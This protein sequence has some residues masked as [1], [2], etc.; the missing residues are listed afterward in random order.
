M[1]HGNPYAFAS[2]NAIGNASDNELKTNTEEF[3]NISEIFGVNDTLKIWLVKFKF[4]IKF[5]DTSS[6]P[7]DETNFNLASGTSFTTKFMAF[8]A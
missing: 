1:T 3:K 4:F 7:S 2:F 6:I 8:I 5:K